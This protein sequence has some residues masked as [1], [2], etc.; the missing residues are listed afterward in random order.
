[1]GCNIFNYNF[2]Y[3][4]YLYK[5]ILVKVFNWYFI[6]KELCEVEEEGIRNIWLV[7]ILFVYRF[8]LVLL[9]MFYYVG[10]ILYIF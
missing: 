8:L 4:G 6:C 1:M 2:N 10:L 3:N 9:Y 5:I 7:L